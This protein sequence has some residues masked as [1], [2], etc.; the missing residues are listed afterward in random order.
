MGKKKN[1]EG[2]GGGLPSKWAS[3][4]PDGF[5]ESAEGMDT[6]ELKQQLVKCEQNI[7]EAEK[8][9]EADDKLNG[10]KELVKD[11]AGAYRDMMNA[12]KAKI[13]AILLVLEGRG[14]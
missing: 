8:D 14:A 13:K 7:Q 9:M 5:M 4:L 3:K 1:N 10:A 12:N 2:G 11:L 6:D